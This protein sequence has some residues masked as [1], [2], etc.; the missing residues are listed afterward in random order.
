VGEG[1]WTMGPVDESALPASH[2]AKAAF[3]EAMDNWD[4]AAADAAVVALARTAAA[5][6]MFE[7]FAHYGARDF[8]DIGHKAI[9]VANSFRA[10][11]AIGWH[12]AEPVLRSLA[13]AL[14]DRGGAKENPS[15]ADLPADRPFRHNLET[16]KKIRADWLDGK[17]NAAAA[18]EMLQVTRQGT[19]A[20]A[21]D[22]AVELLNRGV[23]PQTIF[24]ALFERAGELL[25]RAPGILSLHATTC[26]NALHYSWQHCRDDET[27]RLLLLQNAAYLP[28]FRGKNKDEGVRIDELEAA[29]L[30]GSGPDAVEEIFSE[31]SKNRLS[32]SRKVLAYLKENRDPKPLAD[33]ARRLIFLKG[34]DSHDYKFSSA[35]LEDYHQLA[36]PWRDRFLAASVFNL[37]GSA[38]PDNELVKRTR[39]ALN[40]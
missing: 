39:A 31:V 19:D 4:E 21:S 15:K 40:G 10:L 13:Y 26:T 11:E 36:P 7:V 29:P 14:L 3:T 5:H 35:V 25:M 12:H 24:E 22:K 27:R 17:S 1:D 30:A 16:A 23:A 6:E 33:A 18:A 8:R 38:A 2:K 37:K 34:S 28:L 9:Y 32:A 20:E